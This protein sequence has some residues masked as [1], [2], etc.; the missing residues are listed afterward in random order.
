[1]GKTKPERT[2]TINGRMTSRKT[3]NKTYTH[4]EMLAKGAIRIGSFAKSKYMK[5]NVR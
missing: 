1:V 5:M 3:G 4:A 2:Y